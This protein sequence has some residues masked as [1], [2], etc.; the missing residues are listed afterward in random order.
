LV[1]VCPVTA[2]AA[3]KTGKVSFGAKVSAATGKNAGGLGGGNPKPGKRSLG[4]DLCYH[5]HKE[6]HA[7]TKEQKD[8]L[9]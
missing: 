1:P 8:E 5:S 3:K 2:K 6:F 9:C 4:V 7:L